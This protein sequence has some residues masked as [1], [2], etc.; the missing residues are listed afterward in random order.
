MIPTMVESVEM[1]LHRWKSMS[2]SEVEVNAEFRILTAEV[3]SKTA[4]GSSYLQGKEVF[5]MLKEMSTIAGR[6]YYNP[7]L[8]PGLG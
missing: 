4:F 1:L 7:R 3:I 5:E 8:I 6:N 2:G